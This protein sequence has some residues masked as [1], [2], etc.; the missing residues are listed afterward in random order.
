MKIVVNKLLINYEDEG[1]GP[2]LLFL[3]GW[4]ASLKSYDA[5]AGQLA[6]KYRIIRLDFPGF[7]QSTV[8]PASWTVDDYAQLTLA[9]L[10]KLKI[11]QIHGILAHSFGGRVAIKLVAKHHFNPDVVILMGAAGIKPQVTLRRRLVKGVAKV[12]KVVAG[13]PGLRRVQ[14]SLRERLYDTIGSRDYLDAG[15][16]RQVFLNVINEDLTDEIPA[17]TQRTLLLWGANDTAAPVADAEKMHTLIKNS[18]LVIVPNAA[19]YVF[20]DAPE[21]AVLEIDKVL[22]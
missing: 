16:M 18:Q 4:G 11:S 5:L 7:G 12:G 14:A 20:L 13:L 2:V 22:S 8:P 19:H 21:R 15:P 9:L 3:H 17:I 1:S 10:E 6:K